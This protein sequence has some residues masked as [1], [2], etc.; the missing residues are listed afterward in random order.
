MVKF[1]I[2]ALYVVFIAVAG[3]SEFEKWKDHNAIVEEFK[4]REPQARS[5]QWDSLVGEDFKIN[6]KEII[7][8]WSTVLHRCENSGCCSNGKIC[9]P[10]KTEMI[11]LTFATVSRK[12]NYFTVTA[13]NHTECSCQKNSDKPK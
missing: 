6:D 5:F 2:L 12:R 8:P 4:C 13:E 10:K 11:D 1:S 3:A 7:V 9:L